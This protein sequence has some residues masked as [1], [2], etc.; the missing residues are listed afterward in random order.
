MISR[1]PTLAEWPYRMVRLACDYC[2]RRGQYRKETLL[3]RFGGEVLMPDVR[4]LIA[5][6]PRK[7]APG[8]RAACTTRIC[9]SPSSLLKLAADSSC[10][11]VV[12]SREVFPTPV[13][14][15][16]NQLVSSSMELSR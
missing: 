8:R 14:R 6:C 7:D 16:I 5:Q 1:T 10:V 2:P 3:A 4:H 9:G 13:L 12:T 15:D 11:G